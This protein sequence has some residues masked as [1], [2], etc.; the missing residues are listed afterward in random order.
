MAPG[1][2]LATLSTNIAANVVAPA[3]A[4]V[5][6]NPERIGFAA[7]GLAASLVGVLV[8]PWRLI[9]STQAGRQTDGQT[10]RKADRKADRET[11][12]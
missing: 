9:A 4:L 12:R 7:G 8:M 11:D 6:L 3:N 1:L 10:D 2:V 5:N